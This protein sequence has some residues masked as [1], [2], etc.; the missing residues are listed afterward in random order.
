MDGLDPDL[1]SYRIYIMGTCIASMP[2]SIA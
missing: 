2:I 1:L